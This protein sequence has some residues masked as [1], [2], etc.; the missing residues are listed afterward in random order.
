MT[1]SE[2]DIMRHEAQVMGEIAAL[3]R[4]PIFYG[5]GAPRGDGRLVL[6][7]PG[8]FGNDVYLQPLRTWLGRIGYRPVRSTLRVNAGCPERLREQVGQTLARMVERHPGPV[9]LIGHSRGGMLCWAIASR[10]EA[11]A[12]HL[13]LLGSPAP[14][15][16]AMMRQGLW[17]NPGEVATSSV[18]QAG[19]RAMKMLSPECDVPYCGCPYTDD[20]RRPLSSATRVMSIFSSEDPVV[21]PASCRAPGAENVEVRGTHSGL[22]FNRRVLPHVA[23]FLASR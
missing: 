20:L 18:A 17:M 16:V 11:Q 23:R 10:L 4:D 2:R 22:V 14:A 8:L 13:I 12:S 19:A 6:V 5:Q 1:D 9:A 15:V 7:T 21:R 3:A